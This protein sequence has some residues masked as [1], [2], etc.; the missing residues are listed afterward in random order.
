MATAG[1]NIIGHDTITKECG[2]IE[3]KRTSSEQEPPRF[4]DEY[5][6]KQQDVQLGPPQPKCTF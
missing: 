4:A 3:K 5:S 1:I 6:P 2:P